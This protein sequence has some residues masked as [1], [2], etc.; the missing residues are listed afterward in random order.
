MW[1]DFG[2]GFSPISHGLCLI[3]A[4]V[5]AFDLWLWIC[6]VLMVGVFLVVGLVTTVGLGLGYGGGR[7]S[8]EEYMKSGIL[9][10]GVCGVLV[11]VCGFGGGSSHGFGVAK[12]LEFACGK[13][14]LR[15]F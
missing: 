9:V 5:L 14:I 6:G 2:Y 4:V 10:V 7:V 13:K 15:L 1:I 12:W 8:L 3:L 11:G